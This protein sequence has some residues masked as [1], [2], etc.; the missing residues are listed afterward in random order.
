MIPIVM[1]SIV[2]VFFGAERMIG[3]RKN[4]IVPDELISG[5]GE[6]ANRQGGLDPRLA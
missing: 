2:V 5:L 3:L 4:R 1:M 6:L